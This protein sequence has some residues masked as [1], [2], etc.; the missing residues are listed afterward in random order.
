[1]QKIPVSDVSPRSTLESEGGEAT[2][3]FPKVK[4]VEPSTPR[5][6]IEPPIEKGTSAPVSVPQE[7]I[8][9]AGATVHKFM[10]A[11]YKQPPR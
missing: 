6:H 8:K 2:P 3:R 11:K 9:S 1:M 10:Q 4:L 7:E 5:S